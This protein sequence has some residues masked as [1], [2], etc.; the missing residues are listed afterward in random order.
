MTMLKRILN[1]YKKKNN[2]VKYY[3]DV[4]VSMGKNVD[5]NNSV[6][7]GAE[8]YLVSIGDNVRV[9]GGVQFVTH[10]GGVWVIRNLYNEYKDVDIFG[11]ITVGNNVHIGMNA[12]VMPGVSIGNNCIIG[13]GAIVTKDIPDN[14]VAVGVPA[15]V[16]ETIDEYLEKNMTRFLHTKLLYGEDKRAAILEAYTNGYVEKNIN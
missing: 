6:S 7:F 15:R 13:T 5:I 3:T 1:Y 16:I 11:R 8:P 10:D 12:I 2:P 14:S 9:T 4:G